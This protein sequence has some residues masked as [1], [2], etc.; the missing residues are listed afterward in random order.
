MT[1]LRQHLTLATELLQQNEAAK[2]LEICDMLGTM[3]HADAEICHT[4]G[5]CFRAMGRLNEA[6]TQFD[7]ALSIS[8]AR[9][10]THF[11]RANILKHQGQFD[12]AIQGYRDAIQID[13]RHAKAYFNLGIV[14]QATDDHA[15]ALSAYRKAIDIDPGYADAWNNKG[16]VLKRLGNLDEALRCYQQ[17][18]SANPTA[19]AAYNA[20]TALQLLHRDAEAIMAYDQAIA[21]RPGYADAYSNKST[22]LMRTRRLA[23]SEAALRQAINANARHHGAWNNL[24]NCLSQQNREKEAIGCY[25]QAVQLKP[26]YAEAWNNLGM[27]LHTLRQNTEA[28]ACYDRAIAIKPDYADAYQNRGNLHQDDKRMAEAVRDFAQAVEINPDFTN[29]IG[30]LLHTRMHACD[31]ENIANDFA[32][33]DDL[34]AA[35]API[36]PFIV[37]ATPTSAELQKQCAKNYVAHKIPEVAA[38]TTAETRYR[39]DRIRLGYFSAD[40]HNH[41]TTYLMAE[42]FEKHDK[43]RFELIAFSFGPSVEDEMRLRVRNAFDQFHDVSQQT[44]AQIARLA[45]D[46]EIDIAIDLK[47]YTREARP[48][49]LAH[50]PAPIQVNYLGYPGTMGADFIDYLI[51]DP[52]LIPESA[53]QHYTEQIAYM[54]DSYQVNDRQRKIAEYPQTRA[55]HG[56]P[57]G[58]FVYCC[59]NNNF[60][61]TPDVFESWMR[62]LARVEHSVLWLFEANPDAMN[63]LRQHAARLGIAPPRLVF[64]P[65]KPLPEHLARYRLADLVLDT[66]HYN[67]HTTTSDALWVGCPVLTRLGTTFA[68][69][70]AASLLTAHGVPEL[71]THTTED[72]EALAISLARDEERLSLLRLKSEAGKDTG[73]LFDTTQFTRNLETLYAGML[74]RHLSGLPAVHLPT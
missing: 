34:I 7:Q 16:N 54:P 13:P 5:L 28:L 25:R 27:A 74:Q 52:V 73:H 53:R 66:F 33:I 67:A 59:F 48:C 3:A 45:R 46:L 39:H 62:I 63:N 35:G 32:R 51:A 64:A 71:I 65:K 17:S 70:V 55:D 31:W 10:E 4:R 42:L 68:G 18:F 23:E 60:K 22:L 43:S 24:G 57:E 61:I 26:D 49:I 38:L 11:F 14:L 44:D 50:R 6:I 1:E 30:S 2:A 15:G 56:L 9:A 20:G 29:A 37:L 58:A 40:L 69:R 47:G 19:E 21:I 36:N 12:Q 8:P 41:A 72:Y